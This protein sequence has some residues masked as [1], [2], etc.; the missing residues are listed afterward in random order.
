M[1]ARLTD[2][3]VV[4][5]CTLAPGKSVVPLRKLSLVDHGQQGPLGLEV[6]VLVRP[7]GK[8]LSDAQA[9]ADAR[10]LLVAVVEVGRAE[11]VDFVGPSQQGPYVQ[12]AAVLFGAELGNVEVVTPKRTTPTHMSVEVLA[13]SLRGQR[14]GE[15]RQ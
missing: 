5:Q 13:W 1:G 11:R 7:L 10:F 4:F 2:V 8:A 6:H 14:V 12:A 9:A 15:G 3:K